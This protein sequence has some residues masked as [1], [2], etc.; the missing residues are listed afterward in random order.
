MWRFH[1]QEWPHNDWQLHLLLLFAHLFLQDVLSSILVGEFGHL[2]LFP[3]LHS[4]LILSLTAKYITLNY[5]FLFSILPSLNL[6]FCSPFEDLRSLFQEKSTDQ[7]W[8]LFLFLSFWFDSIFHLIEI[9]KAII[10]FHYHSLPIRSWQNPH[11][12]LGHLIYQLALNLLSDLDSN[13]NLIELLEQVIF[14]LEQNQKHFFHFLFV[15]LKVIA[16]T[17]HYTC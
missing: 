4:L 16:A 10:T 13:L 12:F 6:Y 5:V 3:A 15:L 14:S 7:K 8:T 11:D 1:H 2:K 17:L 9:S